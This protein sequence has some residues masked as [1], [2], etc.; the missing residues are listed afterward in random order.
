MILSDSA[1]A[2]LTECEKW[3]AP[4]PVPIHSTESF[5]SCPQGDYE[6][7][8]ELPIPTT[9][10]LINPTTQYLD[11]LADWRWRGRVRSELWDLEPRGRTV[12][13]KRKT[14]AGFSVAA[15]KIVAGSLACL[16]VR[17]S[18]SRVLF[19]NDVANY[20]TA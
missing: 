7:I 2:L 1:L 12:A 10:Y 15:A 9:I 4:V 11:A 16:G 20:Y 8:N 5:V 19:A 14:V 6:N 18:Y 17:E 13:Q 3:E